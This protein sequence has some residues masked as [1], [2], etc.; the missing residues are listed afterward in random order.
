MFPF[1]E[2]LTELKVEHSLDYC[3]QSADSYS[4]LKGKKEELI[5]KETLE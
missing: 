1:V 4:V 5:S 2:N 3:N